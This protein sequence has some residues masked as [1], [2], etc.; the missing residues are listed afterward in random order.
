MKYLIAV[1]LEGINFVAGEPY[2]A[3]GESNDYQIAKHEAAKEIN[4]VVSA[5]YDGGASEV[6][7][8]DNHGS[9]HNIDFAEVDPRATDVG[10]DACSLERMNFADKYGIDGG[11]VFLGY[12]SKEGTLNGVLA[13][14]YSSKTIQYYKIN[15]VQR[16][17]FYIDSNIALNKNLQ[18][19]LLASDDKCVNEASEVSP[20]V[21][22]VITKYGT[23]RNSANFRPAQDVYEE[24]YS[25][26]KNAMT[27][28]KNFTKLSFPATI[29]IRYSRTETA[30]EVKSKIYQKYGFATE[31]GEDAHV[32]KFTASKIED[33][34]MFL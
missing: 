22:T 4:A 28:S 29:E 15:G 18:P 30:A 16:G 2:K 7:V 14:T 24:L 34:K 1:D 13:H 26:T 6:Y 12:H 32:I 21:L 20:D 23:G 33:I 27:S 19:L 11:V 17:E 8:W 31:Y 10:L 5:L 3:L 9:G 25:T